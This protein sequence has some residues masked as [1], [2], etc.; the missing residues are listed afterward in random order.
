MPTRR[1]WDTFR[2]RPSSILARRRHT[3]TSRWRWSDWSDT[4]RRSR[5]RER[6]RVWRATTPWRATP[7]LGESVVQIA[8]NAVVGT[9]GPFLAAD[10]EGR[11]GYRRK[12]LV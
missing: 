7:W 8:V 3:S 1:L 6:P 10:T 9:V 11:P 4:L 12:P 5:W 2:R